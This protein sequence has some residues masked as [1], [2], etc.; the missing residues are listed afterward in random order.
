[1]KQYEVKEINFTLDGLAQTF[2]DAAPQL[3]DKEKILTLTLYQLLA[4]GSAVSIGKVAE[5]TGIG[6][7]EILASLNSWPA[8]YFDDSGDVTGFWGLTITPMQH[9][10]KIEDKTLYTWCA[11]DGLFIPDLLKTSATLITQCP[12]SKI[13]LSVFLGRDGKT[14]SSAPE[15]VMSF[16]EPTR[17]AFEQDIIAKFCHYIYLFRDRETGERWTATNPKTHLL[18]LP[19]AVEL[20]RLKNEKQFG[21]SLQSN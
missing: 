18:D 19:Q 11:W 21:G 20:G 13:Q 15:I 7:A 2:A 6:S 3:S 9:Q 14:E 12:I 1:M 8:V 16:L 4:T 5:A 10:L 17:G